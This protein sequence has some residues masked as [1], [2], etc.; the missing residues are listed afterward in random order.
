MITILVAGKRKLS[1]NR[2]QVLIKG[3]EKLPEV[4]LK[5]YEF[6]EKTKE[7]GKKLSE[8]AQNVDYIFV[9][10]FRHK[11]VAF[12]KKYTNKKIIFDP[13]ISNYLTKVID[14]K[15]WWKAPLKYLSDVVPMRNCDVLIADTQQHKNY[16]VQKFRIPASKIVVVPVGVILEDFMLENQPVNDKFRVG[17]YGSF[18]P[19]QGVDKIVQTALE[20]K[21]HNDITF[22]LIG[23][24]ITDIAREMAKKYKLT[25]VNFY[26]W[27]DYTKLIEKINTFDVCLGIFGNSVKADF[28]IPNKIFHYAALKK[29]I[30]TKDTAG[31]REIFDGKNDVFLIPNDPQKIANAILELKNNKTKRNEMSENCFSIVAQNYNEVEIAKRLVNF[32]LS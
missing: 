31:I 16:F 3:L 4:E 8:L 21:N 9:P 28:V 10:A 30:I 22:D 7:T 6:G 23:G 12:V 24:G 29:P 27:F 32:L 20:L 13:L 5:T 2:T 15:H 11:D 18:V 19:L 1:Y 17:F 14:Y 26:G 25:N